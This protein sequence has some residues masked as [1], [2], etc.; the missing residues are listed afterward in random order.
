MPAFISYI[1]HN[2]EYT[3]WLMADNNNNN[4]NVTIIAVAP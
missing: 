2:R 3:K 1:G 4:T